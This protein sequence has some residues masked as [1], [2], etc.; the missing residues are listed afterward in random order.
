MSPQDNTQ[1]GI[2]MVTVLKESFK[3][4]FEG[5]YK[6][7]EDKMISNMTQFDGKVHQCRKE[8]VDNRRKISRIETD[9]RMV[10]DAKDEIAVELGN[11]TGH[12]NR[13]EEGVHTIQVKVIC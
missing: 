2:D 11:H 3:E 7:F 9:L 8:M 13:L 12:I 10:S 4:S 5:A 1:D 6:M